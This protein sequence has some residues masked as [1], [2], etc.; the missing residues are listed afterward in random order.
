MEGRK[1]S[2]EEGREMNKRKWILM[3]EWES[4]LV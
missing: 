1:E 2:R 4:L 3:G